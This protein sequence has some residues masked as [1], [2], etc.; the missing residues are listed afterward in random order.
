KRKAE[1]IRKRTTSANFNAMAK[2]YTEEPG[3]KEREGMLGVWQAGA[4]VPEFDVAVRAL[5]PGEISP[6]LVHTSYGWHIVRRNL[7]SEVRDQYVAKMMESGEADAQKKYL[8][9]LQADY[10][11]E[12]KPGIAPK[13]RDVAKDPDGARSDKTVLATSKKGDFTAARLA[14][15]LKAFPPQSQIKAQIV[16]SPDSVSVMI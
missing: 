11:L 13:A 16:N 6:T 1:D 14:K 15:W 12:V 4:M 9:K 3:G 7:F 5:K 8:D 10:K 2:Q